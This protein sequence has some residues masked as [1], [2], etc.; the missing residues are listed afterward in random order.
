MTEL[1]KDIDMSP[2]LPKD[3]SS[4][5]RLPAF[6]Q[7]TSFSFRALQTGPSPSNPEKG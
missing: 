1:G 7:G 4:A 5:G 2:S 6:L 3:L